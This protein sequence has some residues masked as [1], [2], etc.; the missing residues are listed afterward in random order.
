MICQKH[1]SSKNEMRLNPF[2]GEWIIYAPGRSNRPEDK[3]NGP[4][5]DLPA[6][7]YET[8]CPF[9][10]G[11]ENMLPA[12]LTEIKGKDGKWQVRIVPNRYPAVISSEQ[13]TREFAGMYMM[14]KSSGNH[15]V[16]ID[17][18]LHNQAIEMMSL[19][20]AGFLIEA[21]HRR[22]GDLAKDR[23][24]KTVI[25]FRNH[26]KAAGR[27]LSHPHS[28]IITL[29]IIPR[30]VRVRQSSSLAYRRKNLHCLLCDIIEFELRSKIRLIYEN[31]RF[32]C[33][34]PFTAEVSFEVWIVPKMHRVDFRD[35]PDEEKPDFADSIIKV[36][37]I[38]KMKLNAPDYN[39]VIQ[40][41]TSSSGKRNPA[42]HWYL[43]IKP[44]MAIQAGFEMGS[45]MY[46][47]PSLPESDAALLKS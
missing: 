25:L 1:G 32:V 36:L 5:L 16:I 15:E 44:R 29:G 21:Y 43:Q 14:M 3:E 42:L 46:I 20:E 9:C 19:K 35:I 27:S 33:F 47:N 30:A 6:H 23:K 39:Y 38:L 4:E 11:N 34:V 12:I 24:N 18:P 28:Q 37:S 26:G 8:T 41:N 10:P 17:S 31:E 40:G 13:E 22:Y 2:T 7:S 45:G